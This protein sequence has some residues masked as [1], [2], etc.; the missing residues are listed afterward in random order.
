M[1][2]AFTILQKARH[3]PSG[4]HAQ[5]RRVVRPCTIPLIGSALDNPVASPP[6][7]PRLFM[8]P[9]TP[10]TPVPLRL[11]AVW[12]PWRRHDRPPCQSREAPNALRS[13]APNSSRQ[14]RQQ[15]LP[16]K[17]ACTWQ[18][19]RATPGA[20]A[21][22]PAQRRLMLALVLRRAQEQPGCQLALLAQQAR[23]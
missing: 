13:S 17:P 3:R 22:P 7:P 4:C 2:S 5:R 11:R 19:A 9:P 1:R 20:F 23:Q 6:S 10:P 14:N 8:A 21:A 18:A 15:E 16:P 12:A